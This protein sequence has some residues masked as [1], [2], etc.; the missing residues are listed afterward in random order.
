MTKG[1]QLLGERRV[2]LQEGI[3]GSQAGGPSSSGHRISPPPV[4]E[5]RWPLRRSL[6]HTVCPSIRASNLRHSL[7]SS[8]SQLWAFCLIISFKLQSL[9]SF[10]LR[11]HEAVRKGKRG[12]ST[13]RVCHLQCSPLFIWTHWPTSPSP[14]AVS[15]R[16]K[17]ATPLT[18]CR[19]PASCF[20][21]LPRRKWSLHQVKLS[22][23]IPGL[24]QQAARGGITHAAAT[25]LL[26]QLSWE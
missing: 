9:R 14:Q 7:L 25:A 4:T 19:G 10:P 22:V 5:G 12:L 13:G 20:S 26:F 15:R 1:Y 8:Q 11:R 6:L 2:F 24:R 3:K 23:S 16:S 18:T 17:W 21:I